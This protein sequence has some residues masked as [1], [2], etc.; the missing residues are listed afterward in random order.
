[1]IELVD[2]LRKIHEEL[3]AATVFANDLAYRF[4]LN[5]LLKNINR[6]EEA[7]CGSWYGYQ[8]Y[9]Y[10]RNFDS[11]PAGTHFSHRLGFEVNQYGESR[12][13]SSWSEYSEDQV[14]NEL[15]EG[16]EG[17]DIRNAFAHTRQC[18]L[19]FKNKKE[20]IL[21][22]FK[23]VEESN[24]LYFDNL[25]DRTE[26]LEVLIVDEI[27]A[28]D[29]PIEMAT[30]DPIA[31]QQGFRTPP[32]IQ[33]K[34]KVRSSLDAVGAVHELANLVEKTIAQMERVKLKITTPR[35]TGTKVFIGHGRFNDW[36]ELEKFL[37][38]RLILN[39]DEFNRIPTAGIPNSAR[40]S[41]MLDDAC[42]AFLVLTAED[43]IAESESSDEQDETRKQ[44]RMNVVHEAGLF[45]GRLGFD[46]AIILLENGCEEFSNIHGLGQIRFDKGKLNDKFEEIRELLEDRGILS[47]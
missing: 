26:N 12:E 6:V 24:R 36:L 44:A 31:K 47:K 9:V 3:Q 4:T 21:D 1:M 5:S 16:I 27:V 25:L 28:R 23:I 38:E 15:E 20:D 34:A 32:H 37:K 8:A 19:E 17:N 2:E 45:Q 11:P 18:I 43:E 22:I 46:K 13:E 14:M 39:P 33:V 30:E 41:T 42:F 40:L 10:Y 7:W 35:I 29:R